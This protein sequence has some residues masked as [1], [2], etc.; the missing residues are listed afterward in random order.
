M[1]ELLCHFLFREELVQRGGAQH[2]LLKCIWMRASGPCAC[3]LPASCLRCLQ[4]REPTALLHISKITQ[5]SHSEGKS[6][7]L[8]LCL[9]TPAVA[10][11][12]VHLENAGLGQGTPYP[13]VPYL[14]LDS[15]TQE[16]IPG[17]ASLHGS[18]RS[19][20]YM[21]LTA[22][23]ECLSPGW[24]ECAD[25]MMEKLRGDGKRQVVRPFTA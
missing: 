11:E 16:N 23:A 15:K 18:F 5:A 9:H 8:G 17:P 24:Q 22:V 14:P 25:S 6:R 4:P 20:G 10:A 21:G 12:Y 19:E 13:W 1:E 2:L 7:V 3:C